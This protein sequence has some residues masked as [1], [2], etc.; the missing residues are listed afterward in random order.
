MAPPTKAQRTRDALLMHAI[1]R[2]AAV[3]Y[4]AT[5]VA[6]I[7]RQAGMS[8]TAAYPYF[9][10]KED[11][12]AAAVD[13][14]A[15]GLINDALDD[16]VAG[17]FDLD[18]PALFARLLGAIDNHPLARRVLAGE[19]GRG[20]ERLLVLPAEAEVR[21]GLTSALARLQAESKVRRDIDPATMAIGLET[22]IVTVLIATLQT[23]GA[24]D[25]ERTQGVLAV[26]DAA[27][28]AEA[29]PAKRERPAKAPAP[30][31]ASVS[32]SNAPRTRRR[33]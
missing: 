25:L 28:R 12:F 10:S 5:S 29:R 2:F 18:W 17:D 21:R 6:D 3:G 13:T 24:P 33:A 31:H 14:D 9:R 8:S 7:C 1:R 32:R 20:A 23:G 4:Q 22:L 30:T 27:V 19:E 16:V 15:A 26:F 11:L